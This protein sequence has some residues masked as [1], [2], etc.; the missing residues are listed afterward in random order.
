MRAR[1]VHS[2]II[3]V[4][5]A[6]VTSVAGAGSAHA[7]EAA[8]A[9][10]SEQTPDES[11]GGEY[12][13]AVATVESLHAVLL[14]SM[15]RAD[16]LGFE[17]RYRNISDVLDRTFDLGFMA[18]TSIGK[19]WKELDDTQRIA[20]VE[21]SKRY[22]AS[23]YAKN[24]DGWS[25]QSFAT[26]GTEPAA[27]GTVVVLT[28]LVQPTDKNVKLDYRLRRSDDEWRIIDVKLDGKVSEITLRRS[29]YRSVI[30]RRGFEQL[31]AD[32]EDKIENMSEQ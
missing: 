4:L 7:Q 32:L 5:F 1:S 25:D 31:M 26:L 22:S 23:N 21:Q 20:W 12:D 2:L 17:G 11:T 14:D 9:V 16:E 29:D 30:E 24:F 18:R 19:T 13:Q 15:Q 27:H 3:A 6:A 10:S 28:E 8:A